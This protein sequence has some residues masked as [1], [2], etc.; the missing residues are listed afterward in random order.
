MRARRDEVPDA[1]AIRA[2][3]QAGRFLFARPEFR[4]A[5]RVALYAALPGEFPTAELARRIAALG[6]P[7][8]WPRIAPSGGLEFRRASPSELSPGRHGI[9]T[10]AAGAPLEPLNAGVLWLLPGL[11]F[12][13]HGGRLGRGGGAYDRALAA[14]TGAYPVGLGFALQKVPRVPLEAHDRPLRAVLTEQGFEE[15]TP[16]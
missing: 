12:D 13:R 6:M 8:L 15:C 11:A 1:S 10:P 5:E 16:A 9:A 3:L 4:R 2:A 14:A 7:L